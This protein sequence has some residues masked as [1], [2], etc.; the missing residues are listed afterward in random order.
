[1]RSDLYGS[2]FR[3]L[4]ARPVSRAGP[5]DRPLLVLGADDPELPDGADPHL[6]D[7]G[8]VERTGKVW[9]FLGDGETDEP[10]TLGAL[11]RL[12]G[13]RPAILARVIF[14]AAATLAW[15]GGL[16]LAA[17]A[18]VDY[19]VTRRRH[20]KDLMMTKEEVKREHKETEGDPQHRAERKRLHREISAIVEEERGD[21][22]AWL[23]GAPH[24]K[25][26]IIEILI[27][28]LI[29]TPPLITLIL[30]IVLLYI[31]MAAILESF[32]HPIT[33]MIT[34]PLSLIGMA[35]YVLTVLAGLVIVM[36]SFIAMAAVAA[37][38]GA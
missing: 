30:A 24:F 28:D 10:E 26:A 5:G 17:S 11:L 7:R 23:T 4:R 14:D 19:V 2:G 33:V 18:A 20:Q 6:E 25:V 35:V 21:T 22:T 15:R 37:T 38:V 13:A 29:W 16:V 12:S 31:V 1:M 27:H 3:G 32:I 34:L 36:G 9:A 8:L